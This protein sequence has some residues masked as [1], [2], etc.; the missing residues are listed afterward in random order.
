MPEE[1]IIKKIK[2]IFSEEEE[3]PNE[4]ILEGPIQKK[5]KFNLLK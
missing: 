3:K 2:E 4:E 5:C 1:K